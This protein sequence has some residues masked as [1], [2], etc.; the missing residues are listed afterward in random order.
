ML[1]PAYFSRH[2][3]EITVFLQL[4]GHQGDMLIISLHDF[5]QDN[6]NYLA[7]SIP[8]PNSMQQIKYLYYQHPGKNPES[9]LYS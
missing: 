1:I 9:D 4:F 8:I 2:T 5:S 7:G 6:K 3:T